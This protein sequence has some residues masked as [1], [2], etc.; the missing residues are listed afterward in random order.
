VLAG[1]TGTVID[2]LTG[3]LYDY[4]RRIEVAI[5]RERVFEHGAGLA[6][7]SDVPMAG[8]ALA[9]GSVRSSAE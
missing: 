8:A 1:M 2:H 4:P 6:P 9:Q 3:K 7:V 5:G